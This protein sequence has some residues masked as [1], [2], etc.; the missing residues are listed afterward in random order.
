MATMKII[1][2]IPMDYN[3]FGIYA[4]TEIGQKKFDDLISNRLPDAVYWCGEEV[5][6]PACWDGTIEID[7]IISAAR[8]E[9]MEKYQSEEYW[10]A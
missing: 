2:R 8:D 6:A 10:E 7:E 4:L 9:I 5:I 3:D 1:G